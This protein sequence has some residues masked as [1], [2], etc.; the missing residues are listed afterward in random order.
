M[1]NGSAFDWINDMMNQQEQEPAQDN[2]AMMRAQLEQADLVKRVL[3]DNPDGAA[4]LD[5]L[6]QTTI[7]TPMM[8]VSAA[9]PV[10]GEVALSPSDW[11]YLREGQNSVVHWMRSMIAYSQNP[12]KIEDENNE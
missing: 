4:L 8:Q 12:P 11:A 1:K 5:L 3:F 2:E 10:H 9:L 6:V 7:M